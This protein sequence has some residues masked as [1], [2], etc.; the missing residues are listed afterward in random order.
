MRIKQIAGNNSA[1]T[2]I[3]GVK[4]AEAS[5]TIPK[6]SPVCLNANA[7]DDGLAVVL[8]SN[9][10]AKAHALMFG[11]AVAD[12]TAGAPGEVQ[13]FGYCRYAIV[14]T[15]TRATATTTD[16]WS[17]SESQ[18]AYCILNVDTVAGHNC[19]ITSGGT[20]AVSGF[21]PAYVLMESLSSIAASATHTSD[22]RTILT[23]SAKIFLRAM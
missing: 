20:Q 2:I 6:G 13:V 14:R 18:A 5:V 22:T 3:L 16:S 17:S 11:V 7:T 21:L 9:A 15:N 23:T 19:F 1:E 10:A 8:P 12:I 4:S